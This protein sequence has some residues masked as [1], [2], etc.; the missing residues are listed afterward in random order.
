M[1][2]TRRTLSNFK[3]DLRDLLGQYDLELLFDDPDRNNPTNFLRELNS[4]NPSE[5]LF[6]RFRPYIWDPKRPYQARQH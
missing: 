3:Q 5:G 1:K 2:L 6:I 4:E